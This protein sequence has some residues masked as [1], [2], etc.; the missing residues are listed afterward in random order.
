MG[1]QYRTTVSWDPDIIDVELVDDTPTTRYAGIAGLA[2]SGIKITTGIPASTADV[3]MPGAIVS[4]S[5]D[6][7]N[8]Q[9]NGSIATPAWYL[10]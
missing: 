5:F 1:V 10:I 8:W 7:T 4:N 6:S 3:W 2:K 9:N